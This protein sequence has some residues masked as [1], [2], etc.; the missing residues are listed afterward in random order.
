M[1]D[2]YKKWTLQKA[3]E[4]RQFAAQ[5]S[6]LHSGEIAY[7]CRYVFEKP[8]QQN[9]SGLLYHSFSCIISSPVSFLLLRIVPSVVVFSNIISGL[10]Y[11]FFFY[12]DPW[13]HG[14]YLAYQCFALDFIAVT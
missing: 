13:Q 12:R 5:I 4:D 8:E 3:Y 7:F 1:R 6:F 9:F 2:I 11:E 14:Q 10:L